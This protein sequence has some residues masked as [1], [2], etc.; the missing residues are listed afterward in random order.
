MTGG[1]TEFSHFT[2]PPVA[3]VY[4]YYI[5]QLSEPS[6]GHSPEAVLLH[7][8]YIILRGSVPSALAFGLQFNL[9]IRSYIGC[10]C[11]RLS[12]VSFFFIV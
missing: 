4:C 8:I 12:S 3:L 7:G 2:P 6:L 5:F 1:G 11:L 9:L 10:V